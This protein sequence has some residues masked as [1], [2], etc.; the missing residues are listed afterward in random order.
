MIGEAE[1]DILIIGLGNRMVTADSLGPKVCEKVFV[2]R[3]ILRHIPD[4]LDERSN[5]VCAIAPGVLGVT[6]LESFEVVRGIVREIRPVLVIVIDALAARSIDRLGASIQ[7]T[8]AGITPGSGLANSRES[9]TEDSLDVP[10]IAIG[11]PTVVYTGTIISDALDS[12]MPAEDPVA[13]HRIIRNISGKAHAELVVTPKDIDALTDH[14]SAMIA[15]ML[16]HAL[17]PYISRN[18]MNDLRG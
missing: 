15:Q 6:G 7:I 2:T 14:C 11:V 3:H 8:D 16:D 5:A 12:A 9:L 10:V 1:G 4:V 18:E 13:K 17:H